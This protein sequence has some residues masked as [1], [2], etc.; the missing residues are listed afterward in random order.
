MVLNCLLALARV[1]RSHSGFSGPYL[2]IGG[3]I[4]ATVAVSN[5][6]MYLASD[7]SNFTAGSYNQ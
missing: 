3:A 6:I 4:G 2:D 1:A 5:N 7:N